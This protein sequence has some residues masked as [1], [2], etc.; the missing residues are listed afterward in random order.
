[1]LVELRDSD[2]GRHAYSDLVA[3]AVPYEVGNIIVKLT[4]LDDIVASK[5]FAGR[6][7]DHAALPELR[8]L[9]QRRHTEWQTSDRPPADTDQSTDRP[10]Y[11]GGWLYAVGLTDRG[12]SGI[13]MAYR[14][15]MLNGDARCGCHQRGLRDRHVNIWLP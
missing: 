5:E 12:W 10:G 9:Q 13:A 8:E 11:V 15:Q 1:M 6:A 14:Q 7:K 3:T 4:A 2:G